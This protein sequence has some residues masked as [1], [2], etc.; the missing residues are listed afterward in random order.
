MVKIFDNII[1]Y[2][3]ADILLIKKI[4]K[5]TLSVSLNKIDKDFAFKLYKNS[6][7][8]AFKIQI[9]FFLYNATCF[10]YKTATIK[11]C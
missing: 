2:L 8:V 5:Q 1:C 6:N 7:V 11:K 3:I 9:H 4:K 10:K